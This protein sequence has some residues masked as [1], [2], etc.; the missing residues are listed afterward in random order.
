MT[1]TVKD[2]L[3]MEVALAF[4]CTEPVAIALG[5]AAAATLLPKKEFDTIEIWIDPNIYK[6]GMA[7][8]IAG[9]G[10]MQGLDTASALGAYG[11]DP[12]RGV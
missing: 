7:V 9:S 10:D 12:L 11:G 4:G 8:T 6:N 3:K 2:I 1:F 5:A